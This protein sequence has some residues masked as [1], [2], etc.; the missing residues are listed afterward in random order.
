[1]HLRGVYVSEELS[2]T[3][4]SKDFLIVRQE[5]KHQLKHYNLDAIIFLG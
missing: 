1:M 3:V 5:G 4:T 2:E